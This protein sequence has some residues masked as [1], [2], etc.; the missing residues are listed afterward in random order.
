[1]KITDLIDLI[2]QYWGFIVL[3]CGVLGIGLERSKWITINPYSALFGWIG[4]RVNK[5]IKKELNE[6]SVKVDNVKTELDNHIIESDKKDFKKIRGEI[7][8]FAKSLRSG[9]KHRMEEYEHIMDLYADYHHYV[10]KRGF[11]NGYLDAEYEYIVKVFKECQ[12][13]NSFLF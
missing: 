1:M 9:E 13:N 7:L 5:D 6:I 11:E 3:A 10:E 2:N 12:I 4:K 8:A